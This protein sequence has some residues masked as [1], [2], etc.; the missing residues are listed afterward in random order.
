MQS[1]LKQAK[2][3]ANDL[4]RTE[5]FF[6]QLLNTQPGQELPKVP[7]GILSSEP[8]TQT[9][10]VPSPGK[11]DPMSPF[12]QP[13]A[14]PPSQPLPEKPTMVRSQTFDHHSSHALGRDMT[15]ARASL[16]SSPT[17]LPEQ[18]S[19]QILSLVEAL[20][21]AKREIDSQGSR[22]KQLEEMLKQERRA[23]ESAEEQAKHLLAKSRSLEYQ[24]GA[25]E[26]EAFDPPSDDSASETHSDSDAV[27]INGDTVS[28]E[29]TATLR[30]LQ[31]DTKNVDTNTNTTRLQERLE[32]MMREMDEMK[33]QMQKY[34]A[35]AETAEEERST[36]A[37]MVQRIRDTRD[38]K[39]TAVIVSETHTPKPSSGIE[40][41]T[42]TDG[43]LVATANGNVSKSPPEQH[44]FGE[45]NGKLSPANEKQLAELQSAM[46]SA[47][48]QAGSSEG[49]ILAQSAPYA[50]MLGVVLIG[51]GIMTYLNGWQKGE[52]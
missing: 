14:P 21:A 4:H 30:D 42:Q 11:P 34:K 45:A 6:S 7:A 33:I 37:E 47:F 19:S 32:L 44:L 3:Q 22:V 26:E 50:S 15:K 1:E 46:V 13:P 2:Q 16:P 10:G 8:Q 27:T 48:R 20:T 49:S 43:F 25:V 18:N 41:A 40:I 28:Q 36:L 17:K 38:A 12:S 51:V 31:Q 52:R 29:H 9:N 35:R 24:H 5:D 39:S 23:R